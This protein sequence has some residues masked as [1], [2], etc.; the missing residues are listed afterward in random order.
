VEIGVSLNTRRDAAG[1]PRFIM[2]EV[3]ELTGAERAV[4]LL[5]DENGYS[6]WQPS[7]A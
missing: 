7:P 6:M 5:L 3:V 4:L 2:D 1:L